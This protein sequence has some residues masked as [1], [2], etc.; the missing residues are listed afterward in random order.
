LLVHTVQ[1]VFGARRLKGQ[2]HDIFI[3]HLPLGH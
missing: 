3:K 2:S 1:P